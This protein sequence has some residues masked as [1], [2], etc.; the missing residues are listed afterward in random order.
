MSGYKTFAV[1]GAGHIG[2]LVV[3]ELLKKKT[4]GVVSS[5]A[6]LTRKSD[7]HNDLVEK[8]AKRVV[9]DYSSQSSIQSALSGIDVVVSTLVVVDVQEGLAI[10]AK[11]AGVKLFVPSEFG[12]PTDGVTE[13]I[14][15]QKDALKKKLRDE[16]KIPYAAFYN[17]PWMDYVFQKGFSEAIGFDFVN[18]KIVIPGSGTAD[19]SWTSLRDVARFVAHALTALPKDKIEGHHF[20]IEGDRANYNQ[21]ADAWKARTGKNVTVSYRPRSELENAIANDPKD[22]V[23]ALLLD[24]DKG[25]GVVAR[26][27]EELDNNEFPDWKP[28]KA[29]DV[30]VEIYGQ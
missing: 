21:I 19:I 4:N 1:A 24:W 6:F 3:E 11:A 29:I 10:G 7:E 22:Y 27:P 15:G 16:I 18:G 26:R 2:K 20:R 5:V 25:S 12:N 8:G 14:W 9:V 23:S 17:G 30:L 13:S 28:R